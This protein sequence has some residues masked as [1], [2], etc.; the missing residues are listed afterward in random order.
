MLRW[1]LIYHWRVCHDN[2]L[3]VDRYGKFARP[4]FS[5]PYLFPALQ[6]IPRYKSPT[7]VDWTA[8]QFTMAMLNRAQSASAAKYFNYRLS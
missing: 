3:P 7:Y 5:S 8:F 1:V 4:Q 2:L 6:K